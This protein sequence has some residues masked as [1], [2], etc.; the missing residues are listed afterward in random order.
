M[1]PIVARRIKRI[2]IGSPRFDESAKERLATLRPPG[3]PLSMLHADLASPV[4][5]DRLCSMQARDLLTVLFQ[6][7]VK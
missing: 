7:E 3:T 5:L 6:Q 2:G 4:S 1:A